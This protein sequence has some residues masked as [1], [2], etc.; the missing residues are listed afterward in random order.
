MKMASRAHR[1]SS[2]RPV[3][4]ATALPYSWVA[5]GFRPF[6]WPMNIAVILPVLVTAGLGWIRFR[7]GRITRVVHA[8]SRRGGAGVWIGIFSLLV[9]WELIAYFSSPRYDHPT[10]SSITDTAMSH[11]PGR[12]AAFALWL[13]LGW[14]LFLRR[15]AVRR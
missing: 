3:L 9:A 1:L 15:R 14:A 10:L 7:V 6:T 5:A 8:D 12:A 2:P 4:I 11:R 13:A